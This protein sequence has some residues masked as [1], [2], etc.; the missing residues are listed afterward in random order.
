[1][2]GNASI[3]PERLRLTD[4]LCDEMRE[5]FLL[6]RF[7][8]ENGVLSLWNALRDRGRLAKTNDL[9]SR[10]LTPALSGRHY[11]SRLLRLLSGEFLSD[12]GDSDQKRLQDGC[13]YVSPRIDN[14]R[15]SLMHVC[16]KRF[17]VTA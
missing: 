7:N 15:I 2:F 6:R 12:C 9:L 14:H 1:M 10:F 3:E 16:A 17:G 4:E 5:A 8:F 11:E 13:R